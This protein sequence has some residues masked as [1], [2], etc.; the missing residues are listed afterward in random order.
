[1][2]SDWPAASRSGRAS[3]MTRRASAASMVWGELTPMIFPRNPALRSASA[4]LPPI[5]PTPTML[6]T[7]QDFDAI[8]LGRPAHRRGD[9][10]NLLHHLTELRR[11][12]RLRAVA[13]RAIR[14]G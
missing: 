2:R 14:V 6:T 3:S 12:E 4:K 11:V 8:W 9:R 5:R 13:Q 1:M 7:P 10:A